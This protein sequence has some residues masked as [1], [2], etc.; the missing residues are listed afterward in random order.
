MSPARIAKTLL[1]IL[2]AA[3]VLGGCAGGSDFKGNAAS[4]LQQRVM[5]VSQA[6]AG[7]DYAAAATALDE[8]SRDLDKAAAAGDV[9]PSRQASIRNAIDLVRADLAAKVPA[10]APTASDTDS[11]APLAPTPSP[12]QPSGDNGKGNNKNKGKG[13]S[14]DH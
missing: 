6:A 10:P 12:E 14:K 1:A 13:N 9:S 3:A 8:L 5:A 11:A 7:T 4:T 2:L